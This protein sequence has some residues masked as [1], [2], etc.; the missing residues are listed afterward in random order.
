MP[1]SAAIRSA[2]A[3]RLQRRLIR[4]YVPLGL[5]SG[6][7]MIAI[8]LVL[9]PDGGK[10][11]RL[12]VA[13]AYLGLILIGVTLLIGP[14]N[15]LRR[16]PNPLSNDLRR[17]VGI[18]AGLVSVAHMLFGLQWHYPWEPWK[19]FWDGSGTIPLRLDSFGQASYLGL[20]SILIVALLLTISNDRALR[21]LGRRRWK[22]LQRLNYVLLGLITLHAIVFIP[23]DERAQ[24]YLFLVVGIIAVIVGGQIAGLVVWR[25]RMR[26]ARQ[27]AI[28]TTTTDDLA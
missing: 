27:P 1:R 16:R 15:L 7:A 21:N 23:T 4:H 9:H 11:E 8:D 24:T 17:D 10:L 26:V 3:L 12:V 6:M 19:F 22:L 20:G 13:S 28:P 5:L 25:R 14:L 2:K 18:W